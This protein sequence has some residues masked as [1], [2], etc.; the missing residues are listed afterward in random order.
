MLEPETLNNV[1]TNLLGEELDI[2]GENPIS[3]D[4]SRLGA[5]SENTYPVYLG[6]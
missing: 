2:D 3:R 6:S 4:F 1:I 5:T